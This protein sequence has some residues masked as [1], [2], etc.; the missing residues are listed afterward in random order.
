MVCNFVVIRV[1]VTCVQMVCV[2]F[3]MTCTPSGGHM[4][5]TS[6]NGRGKEN[7]KTSDLKEKQSEHSELLC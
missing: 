2:C 7:I 4:I 6:L 5:F 3:S 1:Y